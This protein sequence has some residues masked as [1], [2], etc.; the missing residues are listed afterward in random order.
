VAVDCYLSE[1][2]LLGQP[3]I[4][5]LAQAGIVTA[6]SPLAGMAILALEDIAD[7]LIDGPAIYTMELTTPGGLVRIPI[8]SWQATLQTGSTS[9]VQ[10]VIPAAAGYVTELSTATEFSIYRR[11]YLV[12]G[13]T[14]D[15]EM[16]RAPFQV[17]QT[18]YGPYNYTATVSGYTDAYPADANPPASLDRTL[19]GVRSVSTYTGGGIRIRCAIDWA[20]RPGHRAYLGATPI[21]VDYIN[22]YAPGS[23]QYM[24]I[25]ERA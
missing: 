16:A 2:S 11:L 7:L 10:C 24:D 17:L 4:R 3:S 22:Y 25:G 6:P 14:I 13:S 9:Y 20:L 8:S 15:Y 12:G 19:T 18:D 23:D 5:S 21:L 1:Q